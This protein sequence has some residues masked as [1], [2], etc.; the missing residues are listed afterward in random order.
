MKNSKII[1]ALKGIGVTISEHRLEY[2]SMLL[3]AMIQCRTVNLKTLCRAMVGKATGDSKY[4]RGQRFF[5]GSPLSKDRFTQV[6]LGL[7]G[8]K[9]KLRL[10]I[11]RTNWQVGRRPVNVF[12]V[13]LIHEGVAMPL[14][15]DM[16]TKKGNSHQKERIHLMKRVL[17]H[18]PVESMEVVTA[19]REFIGKTWLGFL[20]ANDIP[21]VIRIR[22]NMLVDGWCGIKALFDHL[23]IGETKVLK[24]LYKI[25]GV[26]VSVAGTRSSDGEL[27]LVITNRSAKAALDLYRERW[28]IECMFKALKSSGFHLEDTHLSDP[29]RVACLIY[30]VSLAYSWALKVGIALARITPIRIKSH[31]R[32]EKSLFRFGLDALQE[33]FTV[34]Y[35]QPS[36]LRQY[37][38]LLSCT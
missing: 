22:Q 31:G 26:R 2:L 8:S 13:G 25:D 7:H 33:A 14:A 5:A 20:M 36:L 12:M 3:G 4:R 16:L 27:V 1:Q 32:K 19:D 18:V 9:E 30:V 34:R 15:F 17:K 38:N 35:C 24:H 29:P 28:Q 23:A 6:M 10:C 21:F 37:L 11:D